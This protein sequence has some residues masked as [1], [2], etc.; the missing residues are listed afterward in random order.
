[1]LLLD[2]RWNGMSHSKFWECCEGDV[3]HW[4]QS[5]H[6]LERLV[7]WCAFGLRFG[8][9]ICFCRVGEVENNILP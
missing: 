2:V 7:T 5:L 4:A 8:R 1:M 9:A 3:R 6:L